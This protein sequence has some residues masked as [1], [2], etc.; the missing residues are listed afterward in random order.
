MT[1]IPV[2]EA[3]ERV[4]EG[5]AP[6]D[7]ETVPLAEAAGRVLA[8]PLT[9]R[10]TQ[11][12]FDA[13]AMDGYAVRAADV[14]QA[15][16][17]LAVI[18]ESAAGRRFA[19]KV[20]S[21]EAVRIFT[22]APVPAG[23]DTIL[24]QENTERLEDGRITATAGVAA[25]RHIRRAGLDFRA[26]ETVL[27]QGRVLDPA[28]LSLAAAAGHAVL[29]V[30]RR[31]LVAI[32]A[33]GDELVPPGGEPGPDQIVASNSCGIAALAS[34]DGARVLD[35][36]IVPDERQAIAAALRQALAAGSDIVVTLGGAS[37]GDHDLVHQALDSEG[38]RLS[39]WKIAMRP[40]KPMMY[41]RLEAARV[42]GLPGNPVSALVCA[43]L[44][45]RP[46]IARLCSR[47]FTPDLRQ[48]ELAAPM[49]ATGGR[50]DYVRATVTAG[51][52]GL[53]ATPFQ[54]QDSSMLSTL[55]AANALIVREAGAPAS[56]AGARCQV[57]MLR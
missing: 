22:G 31:P 20:G 29:P 43:H 53:V 55:A 47:L 27:E 19:G 52:R 2:D 57:L 13:S 37:V 14:A 12:P 25:G 23:A 45:L 34:L 11:P 18:G 32:I 26:G 1:L 36:G 48:A 21:G 3:L 17:V 50:R 35:L 15:P 9:A 16:A 4:L 33:T 56:E 49:E 28:A 7:H 8:A 24:I 51:P 10:R 41:G 5:L 44:F 39:F 38:A 54:I 30:V 40:G 42:L 46:A 6:L